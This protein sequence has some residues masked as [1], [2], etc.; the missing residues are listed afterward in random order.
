MTATDSLKTFA[1][2]FSYAKSQA[3]IEFI[4][5]AGGR[6]SVKYWRCDKSRR[7][8]ARRQVM[9]RYGFLADQSLPIGASSNGRL[10][11]TASDIDYCT[12]QYTPTE[13]WGAVYSY[14]ELNYA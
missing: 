9:Q 10:M 8:R 3:R 13:I 5:Y 6:D 11:V 7:D 12:G 2:L 1:D 14:L 4:D